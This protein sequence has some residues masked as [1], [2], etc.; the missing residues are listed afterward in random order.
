MNK[1]LHNESLD[2]YVFCVWDRKMIVKSSN[3]HKTYPIFSLLAR[4]S[5]ISNKQ[6][7]DSIAVRLLSQHGKSKKKYFAPQPQ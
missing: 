6:H 5:N 4:I 3:V 7:V 2:I 1:N